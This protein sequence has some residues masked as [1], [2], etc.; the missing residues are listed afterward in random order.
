MGTF[1]LSAGYV[2]AYY[3][4]ARAVRETLRADF[5]RVFDTADAIAL[6]T[7]P[8]PSWKF[9]EKADPVSMYAADIFTVPMNLAGIPAMSVPSGAVERDGQQLPVG[10]QLIAPHRGEETLFQIGKDI[11][12]V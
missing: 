3:R 12:N 4:K 5:A 10:F 1:V 2:D 7:S 11:E 9:G 8:V 6:P